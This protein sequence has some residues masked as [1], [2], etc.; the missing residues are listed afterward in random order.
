[1]RFLIVDDHPMVRTSLTQV[2][3]HHFAASAI[4][5]AEDAA[6]AS[7]KFGQAQY[8]LIL[9]DLDLPDRGG[10]DLLRDIRSANP[11]TRVLVL[12]GASELDY[13]QMALS[14]GAAGFVPKTS[15]EPQILEAIQRV[16]SGRRYFTQNLAE[17][18]ADVRAGVG[19]RAPHLTLSTREFEVLRLFG[20]GY[21][22]SEIA[23]RLHLSIK[24]ISTYRARILK[25]LSLRTSGDL[26]RYAVTHKLV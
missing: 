10:L 17:T 3:R 21:A 23:T 18:L 2:L 6:S 22:P 14:A 11:K 20:G 8:D 7:Q 13:G 4:D 12:S 15:A 16:L 1:M 26:V 25:K 9:L 24:T 19:P 5:Q